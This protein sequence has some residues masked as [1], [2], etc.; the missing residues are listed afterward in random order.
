VSTVHYI[1]LKSALAALIYCTKHSGTNVI[2]RLKYDISAKIKRHG[3]NLKTS[4]HQS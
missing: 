2:S 4:D 3:T 1:H